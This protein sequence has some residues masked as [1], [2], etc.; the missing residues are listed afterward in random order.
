MSEWLNQFNVIKNKNKKQQPSVRY[1]NLIQSVSDI[2]VIIPVKGLQLKNEKKKKEKKKKRFLTCPCHKLK[3]RICWLI[4]SNYTFKIMIFVSMWNFGQFHEKLIFWQLLL[5]RF[6]VN[7]DSPF[8][9][10]FLL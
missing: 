10:L 8:E 6:S 9:F 7:L 3:G 4:S 2:Y 1:R 5:K